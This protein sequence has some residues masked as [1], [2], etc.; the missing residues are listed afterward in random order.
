MTEPHD[1]EQLL[2]RQHGAVSRAQLR[3]MGMSPNT[4]ASWVRRGR[5]RRLLQGVYCADAPTLGTRAHAAHLWQPRG[6]VS[7]HA[8]AY[9]WQLAVGEP[10]FVHLTVPLNC[11]RTTSADWLRL[12]RRDTPRD[13]RST[14]GG[15]PVTDI[16]R[17]VF[18]CLTVLDDAASETLLD[19][20]T[21]TLSSD[22][23]LW[24]RYTE[25]L[26]L[27]GS[28]RIARHLAALA[29]GAASVPERVLA[30]GLRSVGLTGFRINEPVLGYI[31]D[32]LDPVLR[33]IV[34]VDGYRTHS[35]R[36]AFQHDRVRQNVLVRHGYTVLRYTAHD[37]CSRLDEV[38]AEIAAAA[39]HAA[40]SFHDRRN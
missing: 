26:G 17:T 32:F 39:T 37:V 22:R 3:A 34:E 1:L 29:P 33:L 38:L 8:A 5:L 9:L 6:V 16:A 24:R 2:R 14:V 11:A 19:Q 23:A 4:I 25:D 35:S 20:V 28:P 13:R 31:A 36:T 27:R 7:H 30:R 40:A 15:L 21:A 12:I 18:D 10:E